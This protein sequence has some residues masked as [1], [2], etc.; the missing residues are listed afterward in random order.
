MYS[1]LITT[2][3][4]CILNT[5]FDRKIT[6]EQTSNHR[7]YIG[8]ITKTKLLHINPE[9][10]P[11]TQYYIH[12]ISKGIQIQNY[13][14]FQEDEQAHF[15]YSTMSTLIA[16]THYY[17]IIKKLHL[18]IQ[19]TIPGTENDH[20]LQKNIKINGN[21]TFCCFACCC[22]LFMFS[23]NHSCLV[24]WKIKRYRILSSFNMIKDIPGLS[25]T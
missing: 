24:I 9:Y 5:C 7:F 12:A 8:C 19:V 1:N 16:T 18:L 4:I 13:I 11:D 21:L 25:N 10:N 6:Q 15:I 22:C 14:M 23:C 3:L 20:I 2:A 17:I